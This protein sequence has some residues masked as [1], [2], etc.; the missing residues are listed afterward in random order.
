MGLGLEGLIQHFS[1]PYPSKTVPKQK[2][3]S[4]AQNTTKKAFVCLENPLIGKQLLRFDNRPH[5]LFYI[6][7]ELFWHLKWQNLVY[8]G[9]LTT[10]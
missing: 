2:N 9:V 5:S 4:T 3:L 10:Y 6:E 8:Y 1:D 7:S